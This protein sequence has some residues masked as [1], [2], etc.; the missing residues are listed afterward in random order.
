L[1]RRRRP[2]AV[3]ACPPLNYT[4]KLHWS[5]MQHQYGRRGEKLR[6]SSGMGSNSRVRAR[7]GM[8]AAHRDGRER[9]SRRVG[10]SRGNLLDQPRPTSRKTRA[11]NRRGFFAAVHG[12]NRPWSPYSLDF[13]LIS[14][15]TD[16]RTGKPNPSTDEFHSPPGPTLRHLRYLLLPFS[17][18]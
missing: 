11:V 8:T 7:L 9:P 13:P 14:S 1:R 3:P 5:A 15:F 10:A 4:D 2:R 18:P 6:F 17:R 12:E 16:P